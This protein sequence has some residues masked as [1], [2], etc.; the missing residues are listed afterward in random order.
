MR[1][2]VALLFVLPTVAAHDEGVGFDPAAEAG[3]F[4]DPADVQA[5]LLAAEDHP[6]I[7]LELTGHSKDGL[8]LRMAVITDPD[9]DVPF[10]ERVVTFIMSQQHGNEPA[11][12]PAA[13]QILDEVTSG[14]GVSQ[15][16]DNQILLLLP[17]SNP[18]GALDNRR[19]NEDGTDINC[20][21]IGRAHV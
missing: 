17:Q 1:W 11:G 16:L 21:Q 15:Y 13:L 14:T 19:S 8:P 18:D 20:D 2:L 3:L 5:A 6:W 4:P 12:T 10:E 7:T 9:S